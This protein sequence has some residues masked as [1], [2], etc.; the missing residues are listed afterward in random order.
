VNQ[1]LSQLTIKFAFMPKDYYSDIMEEARER[2]LVRPKKT[3]RG[4]TKEKSTTPPMPASSAPV[5]GNGLSP[6]ALGQAMKNMKDED[7]ERMFEQMSNMSPEEEAR[8]RAMGVDPGMMKK[9]A[10]MMK[11]NAFLRKGFTS[12]MKNA[13]P[14][15]ILRSSQ[16]TQEKFATMSEEEKKKI[17]ENLN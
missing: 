7:V 3:K 6:D 16:M 10:Q 11:N 15:D 1:F 4:V 12:M 2:A 9:S 5:V 13:K 14:E 8:M 17:L